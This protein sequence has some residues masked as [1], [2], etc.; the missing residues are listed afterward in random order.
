VA[1]WQQVCA[2][3]FERAGRSIAGKGDFQVNF[4][5]TLLGILVLVCMPGPAAAQVSPTEPMLS[6]RG[7][8]AIDFHMR[9]KPTPG[10]FPVV[11]GAVIGGLVPTVIHN[12]SHIGTDQDT[13]PGGT[14]PAVW[15]SGVAVGAM[16]GAALARRRVAPVWTILATAA[17]TA[18]FIILAP[19]SDDWGT[20]GFV[21]MLALPVAGAAIGNELGQDR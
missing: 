21:L 16:V 1:G 7:S 2:P 6:V 10:V 9:Q 3:T 4:I 20:R 14:L 19:E 12:V 17:A 5:K 18:P 11:A 15:G 8:S 13:P